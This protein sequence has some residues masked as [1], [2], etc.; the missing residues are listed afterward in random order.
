MFIQFGAKY[1]HTIVPP[2][3]GGGGCQNVRIHKLA[4]HP[5]PAT[6][7]YNTDMKV[8]FFL[9]GVSSTMLI[10]VCTLNERHHLWVNI[11]LNVRPL[12]CRKGYTLCN[13]ISPPCK[14]TCPNIFANLI[15]QNI[16]RCKF[17]RS[18]QFFS[19]TPMPETHTL[20]TLFLDTG[21]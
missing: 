18:K 7:F 14:I 5:C 16:L 2:G 15:L 21:A 12:N 19:T 11:T 4:T 20:S 3:G 10:N 9:N 13:V 6:S 8:E 1:S 17:L